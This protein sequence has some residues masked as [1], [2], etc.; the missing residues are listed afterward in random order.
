[1]IF[2]VITPVSQIRCKNIPSAECN[3]LGCEAKAG[4]Q[5][6]SSRPQNSLAVG[7]DIPAASENKHCTRTE[8][9]L[10][11]TFGSHL[12]WSSYPEKP[13]WLPASGHA[14]KT[15]GTWT[16]LCLSPFFLPLSLFL[17]LSSIYNWRVF[18]FSSLLPGR[19]E[20]KKALDSSEDQLWDCVVQCVLALDCMLSQLIMCC[21][22]ASQGKKLRG[23]EERRERRGMGWEGEIP[24]L[25]VQMV[26]VHRVPTFKRT[27]SQSLSKNMPRSYFIQTFKRK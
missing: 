8:E 24:A 25:E 26:K 9:S 27:I 20:E 10:T 17:W 6:F 11:Q 1:M 5:G 19:V 22:Q 3:G 23:G 16:I 12:S 14:R 4:L 18:Y 13:L 15:P 2:V 7:G 21:N